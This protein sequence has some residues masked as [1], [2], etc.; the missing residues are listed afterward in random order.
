MNNENRVFSID[1]VKYVILKDLGNV[2]SIKKL[3]TGETRYIDKTVCEEYFSDSDTV[4][5]LENYDI[6]LSVGDG[7]FKEAY[8]NQWVDEGDENSSSSMDII[9][10]INSLRNGNLFTNDEI[11]FIIKWV[12]VGKFSDN[13]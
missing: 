10:K 7:E 6:E 5:T 13:Q 3:A 11:D 4:Y 1:N 8:E 2:Y 9:E 12:S